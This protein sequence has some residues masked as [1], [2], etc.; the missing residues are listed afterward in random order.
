MVGCGVKGGT[1]VGATDDF[2]VNSVENHVSFPDWCATMLHFF[3]LRCGQVFIEN[4]ALKE[5]Q[6][7]LNEVRII[8]E[9]LA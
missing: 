9:N 1:P 6:T 4:S 8:K 5:K 7:G 3:G 2:D